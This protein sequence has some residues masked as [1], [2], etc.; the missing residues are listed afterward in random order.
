MNF[1]T[2]WEEQ[3]K[4]NAHMSRWPWS[5]LVSMVH[6]YAS[7]NDGYSKILEL[8]CGAGANIPF[9][10]SIGVD[11]STIDGSHT[12]VSMI[13]DNFPEIADKVA[14]GDFTKSL[15][16]PKDFDLVVDRSSLISNDN[17]AMLD[18]LRLASEHMTANGR[19]IG[20][21]WFSDE[22]EGADLGDKTDSHT[23]N[24]FPPS[25]DL[26]NIGQIHFCDKAH[27]IEL[28]NKAGL[29]VIHLEHKTIETHLTDNGAKRAWWNFVAEK[30]HPV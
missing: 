17:N 2:E 10:L 29:S 24:N 26:A 20:I 28:L 3:Y 6:R 27:L 22:H 25:S 7:P 23:R 5:D 8:G 11:Y 1:S 15:P 14:V 30:R 16:F 4:A 21:D 19:F 18:G 13:R 9:F 12:A